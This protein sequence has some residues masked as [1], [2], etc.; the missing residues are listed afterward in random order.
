MTDVTVVVST[1]QRAHLLPDLVSSL[2]EQHAAPA[3]EVVVVDNGS[4]DDTPD[5]LARLVEADVS[6][7]LRT[8]RIEPNRG[9]A[10]ARNAGV[11]LARGEVLA[12]TDDDCVVT[13]SWLRRLTSP[14]LDD[15][16]DVVQGRT[17]P[18]P[19]QQ[20]LDRGP[21][22]RSQRITSASGLYETCNIAYRRR[23]V[24]DV[25]G[26]DEG[27]PVAAGEDVDLALRVIATG[28][29]FAFRHDAVVHHEIWPLSFGQAMQDRSRA[30]HLPLL[31]RLR[32][33]VRERLVLRVFWRRAH[34]EVLGVTA[35]TTAA[36]V[37]RPAFGVT[38][39]LVWVLLRAVRH[40]GPT[41][42]RV[43]RVVLRS[44]LDAWETAAT[45]RGAVRYRSLL[46]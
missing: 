2:L 46:L 30:G 35:A 18:R 16:A 34:L 36:T 39:P 13:P 26:F 25:G 31:V 7:R 32:P 41:P 37:L 6:G 45:V 15:E 9:P 22:T 17:E 1:Y 27:F 40:G 42:A 23:L 12:F 44:L 8:H 10:R 5:V 21:W 14:I 20:D 33:E 19:D 29:R 4:T 38:V 11:E 3:H 28:A 43:R 24:R